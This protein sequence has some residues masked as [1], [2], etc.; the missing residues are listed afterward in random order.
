MAGSRLNTILASFAFISVVKL[1]FAV[2]IMTKAKQVFLVQVLSTGDP[3]KS[4]L[5][6]KIEYICSWGSVCLMLEQKN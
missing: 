3:L 2:M 1:N 5:V 6:L 4:R